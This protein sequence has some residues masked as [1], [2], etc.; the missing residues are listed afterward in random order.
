MKTT[1]KQSERLLYCTILSLQNHRECKSF[2]NDLLSPNE[3]CMII[4]RLQI[5]ELLARGLTYKEIS[6]ITDASTAT[7]S[8]INKSLQ[9]GTGGLLSALEKLQSN[10]N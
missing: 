3:R 1:N 2:L 10:V 5:A 6:R 9:Y 4:Q 7:I 8:R